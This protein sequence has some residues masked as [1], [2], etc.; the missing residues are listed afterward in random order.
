MLDILNFLIN[1]P[2]GTAPEFVMEV[3][4]KTRADVKV[5]YLCLLCVT[6]RSHF[7]KRN[8]VFYDHIL[9]NWKDVFLKNLHFRFLWCYLH[10]RTDKLAAR[11]KWPPPRKSQK[12]GPWKLMKNVDTNLCSR[13]SQNSFLFEKKF[14]IFSIKNLLVWGR[15]PMGPFAAVNDNP[16]PLPRHRPFFADL[17]NSFARIS[18]RRYPLSPP[19]CLSLQIFKTC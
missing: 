18:M 17:P 13:K 9:S 15:L 5:N 2:N 16:D 1:P 8:G 10:N 6:L 11:S 14:R 19:F 7:G 3:T 12:L 4:D